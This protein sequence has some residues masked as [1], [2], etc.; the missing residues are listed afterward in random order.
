M[1]AV[2]FCRTPVRERVSR[3]AG[4]LQ[5]QLGRAKALQVR[6]R[7]LA[8]FCP[9][10]LRA[11]PRSP[12][13]VWCKTEAGEWESGGSTGS[14]QVPAAEYGERQHGEA[15]PPES[16]NPLS[17]RFMEHGIQP[18][19]REREEDLLACHEEI[20]AEAGDRV[21]GRRRAEVNCGPLSESSSR[22]T[23][24]TDPVIADGLGG[25][26]GSGVVEG[27]SLSQRVGGRI[28]G[29]T[30]AAAAGGAEQAWRTVRSVNSSRMSGG[31]AVE[32]RGARRRQ[33]TCFCWEPERC[34]ALNLKFLEPQRP[35]F[36]AATLRAVVADVLERRMVRPNANLD[37]VDVV[38]EGLEGPDDGH[39]F[40]LGGRP[41]FLV[42]VQCAG[43]VG[44]DALAILLVLEEYRAE[45]VA[46]AIAIKVEAPAVVCEPP[47]CFSFRWRRHEAGLRAFF[48]NLDLVESLA[49]VEDGEVALAIERGE[50][51]V[52]MGKRLLR[53][54]DVHVDGPIVAAQ[55]PGSGGLADNDNRG[56]P[57]ARAGFC[58]ALGIEVSHGVAHHLAH[59]RRKAARRSRNGR[60]VA[61]SKRAVS[62]LVA[63]SGAL[64][65]LERW[66]VRTGGGG[67]VSALQVVGSYWERTKGERSRRRSVFVWGVVLRRLRGG[68][69]GH[70]AEGLD[71]CRADGLRFGQGPSGA[72][73]QGRAC[74]FGYLDDAGGHLRGDAET[75]R[76]PVGGGC[77]VRREQDFLSHGA[78]GDEAR[79]VTHEGIEFIAVAL[80]NE[81]V[82]SEADVDLVLIQE[83]DAE[84][85]RGRDARHDKER[86]G[87]FER[88]K[89]HFKGD[90]AQDTE[91]VIGGTQDW[92]RPPGFRGRRARG[93]DENRAGETA[94]KPGG[95]GEIVTEVVT[96]AISVHFNVVEASAR[97]Q[98]LSGRQDGGQKPSSRQFGHFAGGARA[99]PMRG[100]PQRKQGPS[101]GAS[102]R[103]LRGRGLL[104]GGA[105]EAAQG[106]PRLREVVDGGRPRCLGGGGKYF[107]RC[108]RARGAA[109]WRLCGATLTSWRL[110]TRSGSCRRRRRRGV[111][112]VVYG[113]GVGVSLPLLPFSW[114][115]PGQSVEGDGEAGNV[116]EVAEAVRRARLVGGVAGDVLR[117]LLH[118]DMEGVNR[119]IESLEK[120]RP[121]RKEGEA[122]A[123][124]RRQARRV[125]RNVGVLG[126]RLRFKEAGGVASMMRRVQRLRRPSATA[127]HVGPPSPRL[128]SALGSSTASPP[129][130]AQR[131]VYHSRSPNPPRPAAPAQHHALAQRRRAHT[132]RA[133]LASSPGVCS[134]PL[135]LPPLTAS[136][137]APLTRW[138][139]RVLHRLP[140]LNKLSHDYGESRTLLTTIES[141]SGPGANPQDLLTVALCQIAGQVQGYVLCFLLR[142]YPRDPPSYRHLVRALIDA[143]ARDDPDTC[144]KQAFAQLA[145]ERLPP[146]TLHPQVAACYDTYLDLCQ[147]L[148]VPPTSTQKAA[149]LPRTSHT[150][151][152]ISVGTSSC[153]GR[154]LDALPT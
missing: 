45:A 146:A 10:A 94:V 92:C 100:S 27:A 65:S 72:Q 95:A 3:H 85:G 69:R 81:G 154:P 46:R 71:V 47:D 63:G 87:G 49:H 111:K 101:K 22:H 43:G 109:R 119:A 124:E 113:E 21:G 13:T 96:T 117:Q 98:V 6:S 11:S 116:L 140:R 84:Q 142:K 14:G 91:V 99:V 74:S 89:A 78:S 58:D 28:K 51:V 16:M 29:H 70:D 125:R 137:A 83:I 153:S 25:D 9:C 82:L 143:V 134:P 17:A 50:N 123:W 66:R 23:P 8:G 12:P 64:P 55:A 104:G 115:S 86:R 147:R 40:E 68:G 128:R 88:T 108:L 54:P 129:K 106:R 20:W 130:R 61:C 52:G 53:D 38:S 126:D 35:A 135:A 150:C 62:K 2:R 149:C 15:A 133:D 144:L 31:S 120:E 26:S 107:A 73:V 5:R 76:F 145:A 7:L 79:V 30:T 148:R 138:H 77:G 32:R 118:G 136:A 139:E 4:N 1:L 19:T 131:T 42:V 41:F 105:E 127:N 75:E 48:G 132:P 59:G 67:A 103:G 39:C 34:W 57:A 114:V 56:T 44:N 151:R 112:I 141:A 33:W 93:E 102:D 37:S 90:A 18:V 152:V 60:G 122:R 110:V 121:G 80:E 97:D 36:Q 24:A